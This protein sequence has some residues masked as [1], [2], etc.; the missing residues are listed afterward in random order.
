M[1]GREVIVERKTKGLEEYSG[2]GHR[3]IEPGDSAR[4]LF[5]HVFASP[6]VHPDG[7]TD[8]QY[9]TVAELELIENYVYAAAGR[10]MPDL[11]VM[12]QGSPLAIVVFAYEYAPAIDTIHRRH[13]DVCFSRTGI[14]RVGNRDPYYVSGARGF[15][16]HS[17]DGV[18]RESDVHVVPAKFG[19][20]IACQRLGDKRTIGPMQFQDK[21]AEQKFWVP[22]HK[23]FEGKE[24]IEGLDIRLEWSTG[25]VNEKIKRVHMA[26]QA[27]GVASQWKPSDLEKRP[28]KIT[29]GLA[30]FSKEHGLLVPEP[31][32]FLIEPA[33]TAG[34]R[35][36]GFSVPRN[37]KLYPNGSLWFDSANDSRHWPEFVHAKHRIAK[38]KERGNPIYLRSSN[39]KDIV[40]IV[41]DGGYIAAN[42]VD[43][44]A[45]GWIDVTCTALS[46]DVPK[47]LA[48]YSI[49]GQPDFFPLVKQQD[50][51]DWWETS[52]PES[53]KSGIWSTSNVYLGSL[54]TSRYPANITLKGSGFDS[55]D[56]TMTAIISSDRPTGPQC[57]ILADRPQR[58]STLSYR[59]ASL[60]EPGWDVTHDFIP[61]QPPPNGP[62][63]L[64]HYGLGSPYAEDT[65]ICAALGSFCPGA[66]PDLARFF[67][68]F[69]EPSITPI[70]DE[71]IPGN[72]IHPPQ[73]IRKSNTYLY[74]KLAYADYV[75]DIWEGK[76]AY[77]LSANITLDEYIARTLVLARVMELQGA[78][79]TSERLKYPLLAFR[80]T[81]QLDIDMVRMK[82]GIKFEIRKTYVITLAKSLSA[83]KPVKGNPRLLTTKMGVPQ[84]F[85]A[86]LDV[87]VQD[88]GAKASDWPF[89]RF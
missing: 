19:A 28:F 1:L 78:T 52:A 60:F 73:K 10:S 79:S 8:E 4:S 58:E 86:S 18:K 80:R 20:F 87:V 16:P 85:Y 48:A 72:G 2:D 7:V 64:S 66:A 32:A 56:E 70:L 61:D 81:T 30:R 26:L 3:G 36:V 69:G 6:H 63:F 9:P 13:A 51:L 83:S 42:F 53:V 31:H 33:R 57:H 15:F 45:D 54:S 65:L 35:L 39:A 22:I 43:Y 77:E 59:A 47:H 25:H 71:Q 21:D 82:T 40:E 76:F 37:H 68:P 67:Q 38:G 50:L 88:G 14:S 27:E 41:R 49:I 55:T 11:R 12:A 62:V 74:S 75:R 84:V 89:F 44:T 29:T 46:A 34:G 17:R 24:C 5:F 23:L